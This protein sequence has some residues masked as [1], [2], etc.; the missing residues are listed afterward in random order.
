MAVLFYILV[1]LFCY[2]LWKALIKLKCS[3]SIAGIYACWQ[4]YANAACCFFTYGLLHVSYHN[5][6]SLKGELYVWYTIYSYQYIVH[7]LNSYCVLLLSA[8]LLQTTEYQCLWGIYF[9]P[10]LL[11]WTL[12]ASSENYLIYFFTYTPKFYNTSQA[13]PGMACTILSFLM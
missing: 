6:G 9:L 12:F 11:L 1:Q 8:G 3:P 7:H 2:M 10:T 5:I 13:L 4:Q